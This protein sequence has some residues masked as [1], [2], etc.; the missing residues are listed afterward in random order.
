MPNRHDRVRRAPRRTGADAG[1]REI[2][3]LSELAR[4]VLNPGTVPHPPPP[5]SVLL[6][7]RPGSETDELF[8]DV[9]LREDLCLVRVATAAAAVRTLAE[10]PV[11]LVIACPETAAAAVD[12]VLAA[13]AR[14]RPGT[15]VLA[16]RARQAPEP[17]G[18]SRAGVA[19]LRMPLLAGVL[20]RSIDVVLGM[21]GDNRAGKPARRGR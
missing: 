7:A 12:E 3:A 9:A 8:S 11:A 16:V 18:W 17:A 2:P 19:V 4:F 14:T 6:L 15:P 21:N 10:M 20:T 13:V 1:S 5:P